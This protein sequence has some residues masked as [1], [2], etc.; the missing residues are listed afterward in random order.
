MAQDFV[1][2]KNNEQEFIRTA[3]AL[4]ITDLVFVY[5]M[6]Q[7]KDAPQDSS[8]TSR[9]ESGVSDG[10]HSVRV[11]TATLCDKPPSTNPKHKTFSKGTLLANNT[12]Y[13]RQFAEH[14]LVSIFFGVEKNQ[15]DFI[16]HRGSGLNQIIT[17]ILSKKK[18]KYYIDFH[19]LLESTPK[20]RGQIIGR[21]KQNIMLCKKDGVEYGI[22]TFAH[23]PWQMRPPKDL[24]AVM[25]ILEKK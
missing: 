13:I 16:H 12:E 2:P 8:T 5:G 19:L 21:M 15:K 20:Q 23:S 7:Q 4:G 3:Q 22:A 6:P 17:A 11:T 24:Q 25:R 10:T 14:P 18:K 9:P 1:F